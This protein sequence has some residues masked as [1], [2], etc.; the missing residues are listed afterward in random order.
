MVGVP[1]WLCWGEGLERDGGNVGCTLY[2][3][4]IRVVFFF[5]L[6]HRN[7]LLHAASL[8]KHDWH[9][10]SVSGIRGDFLVVSVGM[11]APIDSRF[12]DWPNN[13]VQNGSTQKFTHRNT[14]VMARD[15]F[16]TFCL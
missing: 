13:W 16:S 2:L 14:Q 6:P 9:L 1:T 5:P 15:I 12:Y 7:P 10:N 8:K 3:D 11:A 4:L